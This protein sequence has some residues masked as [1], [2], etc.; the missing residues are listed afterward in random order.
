MRERT[1]HA[2][3]ARPVWRASE[4]LKQREERTDEHGVADVIVRADVLARVC[5][6][7]D[8]MRGETELG[9][10]ASYAR[11]EGVLDRGELGLVGQKDLGGVGMRTTVAG[12]EERGQGN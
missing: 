4:S 1:A 11:E 10:I 7:V 2:A 9:H 3:I 8:Y 6:C 5:D 12:I